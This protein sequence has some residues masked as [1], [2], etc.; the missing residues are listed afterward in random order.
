MIRVND[1]RGSLVRFMH[2]AATILVKMDPTESEVYPDL[3]L[4][5]D[6]DKAEDYLHVL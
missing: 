6:T 2:H 4:A 5:L 1:F 3:V